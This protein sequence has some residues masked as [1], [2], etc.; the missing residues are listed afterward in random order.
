M[1]KLA[2]PSGYSDAYE[3]KIIRPETVGRLAKCQHTF[4]LLCVLAMYSNGNKVLNYP[5]SLTC[6]VRPNPGVGPRTADTKV[7]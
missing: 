3:C 5:I 7:L 6:R 4:H 2:S 1:E